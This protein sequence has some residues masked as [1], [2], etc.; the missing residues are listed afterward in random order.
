MELDLKRFKTFIPIDTLPDQNMTQL[1]D[2][3]Q[4]INYQQGEVVFN[5]G[6]HDSDSIYLLRGELAL[7]DQQ[8]HQKL[9]AAGAE[10]AE[11]ALANLKPRQYMATVT[12][13]TAS[14]A[15]VDSQLLEKLLAWNQMA[16]VSGFGAM[17]VTE[18]DSEDALDSE[19]MLA[20][21]QTKAFLKLPSENIQD[22]FDALEEIEVKA[23]DTIIRQGETGDFYYM[24]KQGLCEISRETGASPIKLA[25]LAPGESFGEEALISEQPRNATVTMKTDGRL[26]RLSKQE[27]TRLMRQPMLNTVSLAEAGQLV[28][29]GAVRVDVR[30]ENEFRQTAVPHSLNIPL[31]LIRIQGPKLDK[32]KKYVLYCDTGTRSAAAAFVLAQMGLNVYVLE[33]GLQAIQK[34]KA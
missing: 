16:S 28:R 32:E 24:I 11:Y 22:L 17:E 34:N 10:Q 13:P 23:G 30:L 26:M 31:Y 29:E 3:A 27:F 25:E 6:D 21:V 15:R 7:T 18:L 5:I 9:I 20:M 19:W 14:I 33:G 4:V 12:S 1:A 8:G 2:T